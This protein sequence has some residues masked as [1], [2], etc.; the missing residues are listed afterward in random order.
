MN[1]ETWIG[2]TYGR[3]TRVI[4]IGKYVPESI[5]S[6]DDLSGMVDTNDG[7]IKQRTG[8][9]FRHI[10]TNPNWAT[11]NMAAEACK[12]ALHDAGVKAKKVECLI[13][14]T[15]TPD[16]LIP[17]TAPTVAH[18]IG[19]ETNAAAFDVN[20]GCSGF[21]YGLATAN[22]LVRIGQCKNALVVG[23]ETLSRR[24][25]YT[26]R[27]TCVIFADGAG[28]MLITKSDSAAMPMYFA[29]G[30]DGSKAGLVATLAG[31]SRKPLTKE[32]IENHEDKIHMRGN[33][34]YPVAVMAMYKTIR[35]V[36]D[37]SGIPFS[38]IDHMISHQMNL[39]IIEDLVKM[40]LRKEK[41]DP[42]KVIEEVIVRV[43]EEGTKINYSPLFKVPVNIHR[44]GNTSAAS[45]PILLAE[46]D[47]AGLIK[48]NQI[49]LLTSVGAGLDFASGLM[50]WREDSNEQ[51]PIKMFDRARNWMGESAKRHF[52]FIPWLKP[53]PQEEVA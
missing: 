6:N 10:L 27:S 48:S 30:S 43:E 18:M 15:T 12:E 2:G 24:V 11:S 9:E 45:I 52:S 3:N 13:L 39:R 49:V 5:L 1:I 40:L 31:G 38:R 19:M 22:A 29:L 8:I 32:G 44:F 23:A 16:Q 7:W 36:L 47:R 20:A 4:G 21:V 17:G 50:K 42:K 26:D 37:E 33:E 51:T 28:A 34:L 41:I 53:N 35:Q 25:N 46:S 14:A